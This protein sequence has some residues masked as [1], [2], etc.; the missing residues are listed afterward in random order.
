VLDERAEEAAV[1]HA[2]GE[3]RVEGELSGGHGGP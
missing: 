1:D 2:D 3:V